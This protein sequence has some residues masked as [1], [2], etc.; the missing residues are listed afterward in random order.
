MVM[1]GIVLTGGKGTRLLPLTK[2]TNKHLTAIYDRP[3]VCYPIETLKK[4]GV[5]DIVVVLGGE[6]VGDIVN[7]LGDGSEFGVHISYTYQAKAGGIAEAILSA[8][9]ILEGEDVAVILG[10]N[11]FTESFEDAVKDFRNGCTLFYTKTD[12]PERFGVVEWKDGKPIK[13]VE[14]PKSFIS[15][16][17][18]VGLYLYDATLFE[19]IERV[20]KEV[21]YSKRG[22]LEV[23][24]LN[25]DYLHDDF[26]KMHQIHDFW[27]DAGTFDTLLTCSEEMHKRKQ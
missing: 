1:K 27:S 20:K 19:R 4:S 7:F 14:K 24:D 15:N 3:M 16:D 18:V 5:T 21:G 25:N 17:A 2:V 8:K 9:N 26:C 13:L 12:T 10:D 6:S 11:I 22:E 23:T